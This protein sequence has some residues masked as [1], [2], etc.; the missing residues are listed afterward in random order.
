MIGGRL[1]VGAGLLAL[2]GC[3][4]TGQYVRLLNSPDPADRAQA[5]SKL[6]ASNS[7]A[8]VPHLIERLS[9][10]DPFVRV[11]AAFAL[12]QITGK[13]FRY[14]ARAPR[15]EREQAIRR[16]EAWWRSRQKQPGPGTAPTDKAGP[17]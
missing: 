6:A 4:P 10:E 7:Q 13:D 3:D 1:L 2:A 12:H 9:D 16:W 17:T 15:A 5:T 8:S 14:D 11:G